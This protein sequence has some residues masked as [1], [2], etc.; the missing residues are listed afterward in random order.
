MV[1]RIAKKELIEML[2]DGRF[3]WVSLVVLGLLGTALVMGFRH[4][5]DLSEQHELARRGTRD[6]WLG[7]GGKNPHSAAHYGIYA[8]K[9]AMALSAI[10]PGV[11]PYVGV[12]AWLEAHRQNQF[13]FRPAQDATAVQRFGELTAATVLQLLI[14]LLVIVLAFSAFAG[15]RE[16]GTLRQLLSLGVAPGQLATGKALG[17]AGAL[18]SV[19]VP[20]AVIG[21][22]AMTKSSES[23]LVAAD[24]PR[25]ALMVLAYVMYFGV[26]AGIALA[27]SAKAPSSRLALVALLGF[28]IVNGL[29][30]PRAATDIARAV[31]PS[32]SA[33]AFTD[34]IQK[35]LD[36][37]LDGRQPYDERH[38]AFEKEV[39]AKYG[40]DKVENLPVNFAGLSLQKGEEWGNEVFDHFYGDLHRTFHEQSRVRELV[41][42]F[43]P[44][45]A[46]Q[47]LSMGLAGTDFA[48]H[49]DFADAAEKYRR[50]LVERMNLDMAKNAGKLDYEYVASPELWASVPDF[51]YEAPSVRWV[52]TNHATSAVILILWVGIAVLAAYRA[53]S[54]IQPA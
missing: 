29:I 20:A 3:R 41:S 4:E 16:S 40:V 23:A 33:F 30:A 52:L 32:P 25:L 28:W 11:D 19:L 10:D 12:A 51:D 45:L 31:H 37:G 2:R 47:A 18:L 42:A 36:S 9:P 26:F 17:I 54:R 38:K 35:A 13:E 5:R 8:F 7:Q 15:E 44:L 53:A 50:M 46:V 21:V 49:R 48:Q 34:G 27:V 22:A 14:P 1:I 6:H 43:A 24:A 39:L